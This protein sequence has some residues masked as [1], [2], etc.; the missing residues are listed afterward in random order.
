M[1]NFM[2]TDEFELTNEQLELVNGAGN[3]TLNSYNSD[4]DQKAIQTNGTSAAIIGG[5]AQWFSKAN[6]SASVSSN[7]TNNLT[8]KQWYSWY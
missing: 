6:T 1:N 7:D 8:Q 5:T 3:G 2:A 4:Q